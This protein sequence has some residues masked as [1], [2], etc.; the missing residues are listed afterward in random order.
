M[1]IGLG[2]NRG[3]LPPKGATKFPAGSEEAS[4][5]TS[6][7]T[8]LAVLENP[9]STREQRRAAVAQYR[10]EAQQ[11]RETRRAAVQAAIGNYK[12]ARTAAWQA[13]RDALGK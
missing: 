2:V 11:A 12:A 9:A 10:T 1:A 4:I 3:A 5:T 13:F 6:R 7:N 8:L